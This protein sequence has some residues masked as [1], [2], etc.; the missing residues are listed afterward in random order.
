MSL[1][2]LFIVIFIAIR[3]LFKVKYLYID[4]I[5]TP[6]FMVISA[7]LYRVPYHFLVHTLGIDRYN[8][9]D[10]APVVY[11]AICFPIVLYVIRACFKLIFIRNKIM[12]TKEQ[13]I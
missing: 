1:S 12:K 5:V 6:L 10:L 11:W 7:S 2:M 3:A 8:A 13:Q 4:A 9:Y